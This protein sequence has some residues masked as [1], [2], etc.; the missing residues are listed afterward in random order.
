MKTTSTATVTTDAIDK[1][2]ANQ[3]FGI[4]TNGYGNAKIRK[5]NKADKGVFTIILGLAPGRNAGRDDMCP[6][7][8]P[9]CRAGCL[10]RA[11]RGY[12]ASIQ[13]ARIKRTLLY[14]DHPGE[15]QALVI[16]DIYK[17][18][19]LCREY[20]LQPAVRLNGTS[21]VCWE[22]EWPELF[23]MFPQVQFYDYT[24]DAD[25]LDYNHF[26]P[27]NY[28]LTFSRSEENDDVVDQVLESGR[29]NVAVVFDCKTSADL[30]TT[31]RGY[32][33]Y[34]GEEDDLRFLDP[35]P[36][37]DGGNVIGLT[38]KGPARKDCS[39]FVVSID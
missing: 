33:V 16:A 37:S 6:A 38:A 4:F 14:L 18:V 20:G 7:A 1:K 35:M 19:R 8:S 23:G 24:K 30:P 11:G 31:W 21:D 28:H 29:A 13:N 12:C 10:Y 36:R 26:L 2:L 9:G 32:P 25:R 17:L 5:S 15:F 22:F 39:G 27:D 3:K 34:S